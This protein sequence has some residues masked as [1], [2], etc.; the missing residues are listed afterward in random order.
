MSDDI[1]DKLLALIV[2][3]GLKRDEDDL[4][5]GIYS[6]YNDLDQAIMPIFAD[7]AKANR[8]TGGPKG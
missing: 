1:I 5:M 3:E 6:V 7:A 4:L 8:L 2:E